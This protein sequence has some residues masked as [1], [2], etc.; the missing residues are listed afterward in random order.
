MRTNE[1]VYLLLLD[2]GLVLVMEVPVLKLPLLSLHGLRRVSGVQLMDLGE[3]Q[4]REGGR[5]R[6]RK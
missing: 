5:E 3:R 1:G 4:E 2:Q 6:E